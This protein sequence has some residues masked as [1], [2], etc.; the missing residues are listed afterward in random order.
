MGAR[1]AVVASRNRFGEVPKL[2]HSR[3]PNIQYSVGL[4]TVLGE[5]T[6]AVLYSEL[7]KEHSRSRRTYYGSLPDLNDPR[8]FTLY[9]STTIF[10]F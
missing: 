10:H 7:V 2:V 5:R 8:D 6:A 9:R 1:K 3:N 4:A